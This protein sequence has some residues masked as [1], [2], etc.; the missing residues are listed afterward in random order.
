MERVFNLNILLERLFSFL[1]MISVRDVLQSSPLLRACFKRNHMSLVRLMDQRLL[2]AFTRFYQNEVVAALLVK[3]ISTKEVVLTGGF[4]LA[5]LNGED[6][7]AVCQDCDLVTYRESNTVR[8]YSFKV[9]GWESPPKRTFTSWRLI[10]ELYPHCDRDHLNQGY[11]GVVDALDHRHTM[12]TTNRYKHIS[13]VLQSV[14]SYHINGRK[15]QFLQ[16]TQKRLRNY[17]TS[18]D[19]V[20]CQNT[21]DGRH[22]N[23]CY[24][25][26]IRSR[27]CTVCLED[28]YLL[29]AFPTFD[30]YLERTYGPSLW[31]RLNKYTYTCGYCV[32]LT[33]NINVTVDDLLVGYP[34]SFEDHPDPT[35]RR[36]RAQAVLDAWNNFWANKIDSV[37]RQ[38]I[39]F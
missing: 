27:E 12:N 37:T 24:P 21:Y 35:G 8:D 16:V 30:L 39:K 9:A 7:C 38:I 5:I 32:Q 28:R 34:E 18:F 33:R 6:V 15:L 36:E 14:V 29:R 11:H 10:E 1:P 19:L 25:D 17:I 13:R 3:A 23:I 26:N 20:I 31:K 4:L 22:V 2:A